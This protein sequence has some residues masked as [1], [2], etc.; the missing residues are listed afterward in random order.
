VWFV[1]VFLSLSAASAAERSA[2]TGLLARQR[3]VANRLAFR[4]AGCWPLPT[5]WNGQLQVGR[6]VL[7]P[8]LTGSCFIPDDLHD[9]MLAA[10][11]EACER[12]R[13]AG[14]VECRQN[15]LV[16]TRCREACRFSDSGRDRSS[17][18]TPVIVE[19]DRRFHRTPASANR[20]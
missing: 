17:K 6:T 20:R 18:V 2:A 10:E 3:N 16:V 11:G 5:R 19:V 1:E 13:D 15:V 4:Q 7:Q 9:R 12:S 8:T 14:G